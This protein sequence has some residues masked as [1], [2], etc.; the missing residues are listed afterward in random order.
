MNLDYN[1]LWIENE[2]RSYELKRDIVKEIVEKIGFN[3]PEPLYLSG[4]E[5]LNGINFGFYD[6]IIA[7]FKLDNN[8]KG[9]DLLSIIRNGE[10]R[11]YTEVLF[12]SSVGPDEIREELKKS[13]IDG[14]YC[15]SRDNDLFGLDV[16]KIIRTL[17]R[18]VLDINN[19]RGMFMASVATLDSKMIDVLENYYS[20]SPNGVSFLEERKRKAK[21]NLQGRIE[22]FSEL[23]SGEL[24]SHFDFGAG[25]R[26]RSII[27]LLNKLPPDDVE[28]CRGCFLDFEEQILKPRNDLAH[29]EEIIEDD[30]RYLKSRNGIYTEDIC[31][32]LMKNLRNHSENLKNVEEQIIRGVDSGH[33]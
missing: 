28:E 13:R 24:F 14:A 31:F 23:N 19:M 22:N 30:R 8:K 2:R 25:A 15:I 33:I 17:V 32:D 16:E 9:T 27:S 7:D 26:Y 20:T 3:F 10:G 18:K 6:L 11:V 12:Y 29:V 4:D 5:N 1:V 21:S